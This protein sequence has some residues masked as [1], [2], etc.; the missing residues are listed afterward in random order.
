MDMDRDSMTR[1]LGLGSIPAWAIIIIIV[2]R[3][4]QGCYDLVRP[5]PS[6][7]LLPAEPK[8]DAHDLPAGCPVR[9]Q[10]GGYSLEG[11]AWRVQPGRY[12]L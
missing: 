8:I 7:N 10:P 5:Q 11:T 12:S 1:A 9:V 6:S 3:I 2:Q 4:M